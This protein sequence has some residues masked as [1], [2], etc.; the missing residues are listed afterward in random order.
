MA[1]VKF[2]AAPSHLLTFET[3]NS[4]SR[5]RVQKSKANAE[6]AGEKLSG[7]RQEAVHKLYL[8][9]GNG[10]FTLQTGEPQPSVPDLR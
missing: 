2:F 9:I 5:S 7:E 6:K 4:T 3:G 10:R 1:S 8:E